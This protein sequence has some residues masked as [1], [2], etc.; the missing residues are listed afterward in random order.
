MV[1]KTVGKLLYG[2]DGAEGGQRRRSGRLSSGILEPAASFDL[3]WAG[4]KRWTVLS[5]PDL[6]P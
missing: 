2:G 3:R 1:E 6:V 4:E 5:D